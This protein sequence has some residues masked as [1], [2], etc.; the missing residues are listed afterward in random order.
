MFNVIY[1]SITIDL[2]LGVKP[3]ELSLGTVQ[4]LVLCLLKIPTCPQQRYPT[5]QSYD[6][7]IVDGEIM[8]QWWV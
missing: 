5:E 1:A 3:K 4:M 6:W 8:K 7:N 2:C